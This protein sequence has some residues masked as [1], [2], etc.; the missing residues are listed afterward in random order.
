MIVYPLLIRTV[1]FNPTAMTC[2]A[3]AFRWNDMQRIVQYTNENLKFVLDS[4]VGYEAREFDIPDDRAAQAYFLLLND[5]TTW[6][7]G[8][9]KVPNSFSIPMRPR[10]W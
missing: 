3:P 6:L 5:E 1:V 2:V 7:L 4:I 10:K 9:I 8:K